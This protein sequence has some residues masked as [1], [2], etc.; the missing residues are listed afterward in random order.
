VTATARLRA[1]HDP[2]PAAPREAADTPAVALLAGR[3]TATNARLL[4]ALERRGLEARQIGPEG[5]PGLDPAASVVLARL[6]VRPTLDGIEAGFFDLRRLAAR[7]VRV[8]N[9]GPALFACHDKLTTALSLGRAGVPHPLTAYVDGDGPL[10]A[11]DFPVVVKPRFGRLAREVARCRTRNDLMGR[12]RLLS[13]RPW[14]A[15]HGAIVQEYLPSG[16]HELRLVVA[17]GRVIG[18]AERRVGPRAWLSNGR[19]DTRADRETAVAPPEGAQ[20]VAISAAAAVG[21]HLVGV[22]LVRSKEGFAVLD[23]NAAV[24]LTDR[25]SPARGDVFALAAKALAA[26]AV[27][28][29]RE[30]GDGGVRYERPGRSR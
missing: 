16:G 2:A 14:F 27:T 15:R 13:G 6:E 8:L 5:V 17:C 18:A 1:T 7:G 4:D 10:P 29:H 3:M 22:D 19:R 25:Y 24:E 26:A 12:L 28:L 20:A 11:L 30:G 21:A 9:P 23:L